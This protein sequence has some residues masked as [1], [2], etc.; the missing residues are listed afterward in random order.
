MCPEEPALV[1][2]RFDRA[3]AGDG[4]T[5]LIQEDCCQALG[6]TSGMKY[7]GDGGPGVAAIARLLYEW[8][9]AA[10]ADVED[11]V[12]LLLF[13]LFIGNCDAHGKNYS[14]VLAGNGMKAS[15]QDRYYRLT[16]AYDLASTTFYPELTSKLAMRYG[17]EARIDAVRG[18]HLDRLARDC[19]VGARFVRSLAAELAERMRGTLDGVCVDAADAGFDVAALQAHLTSELAKRSGQIGL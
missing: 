7:E 5:R 18:E 3:P 16:P 15:T 9:A 8:S 10:A 4:Y 14:L 13:N 19:G 12:R 2:Q 1:V 17:G 11:F 6:V